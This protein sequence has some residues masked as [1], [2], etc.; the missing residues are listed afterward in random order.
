LDARHDELTHLLEERMEQ[1]SQQL[2]FELAAR[3]RDQ[4]RAVQAVRE[5]QRVVTLSKLDQDV[6]GLYRE[7]DLVELS[8]LYIR[9]GRVVEAGSISH[10]RSEL[11]DDEL[12]AGFLRDHY[13]D[14]GSATPPDEIV[15]PV[16]PEGTAGIEEWLAERRIAK[17]ESGTKG[18]KVLRCKVVAAARGSRK[19]LL[20]LARDNARHAFVEKRRANED[21]Q[22]RL[23]KLQERLR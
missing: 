18:R 15:V 23:L 1:S 13:G 22:A 21:M 20:E 9:R 5:T 7:G 8:V 3:Y 17:S 19:Q 11:P 14:E 6:L 2:E 4:L 10:A 12:V 16:L